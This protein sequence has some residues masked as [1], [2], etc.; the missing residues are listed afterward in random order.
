[1]KDH[2]GKAIAF[3]DMGTNSMRLMIVR[4]DSDHAYTILTR[5]KEMIRLGEGEFEHGYIL[6][7]SMGRAVAVCK[8]FV[9]MAETF[10]A[11]ELVCVATAAVREANNRDDFLALIKREAGLDIHVISGTE[12]ARLIYLG[13]SRGTSVTERSLFID[14]GGGS[15][16]LVVGDG[17]GYEYLDS[18]KAGAIRLSMLLLY[19]PAAP[20]ATTSYLML[21]D[22]VRNK[23]IRSFQLIR[24]MGLMSAYGSSGTVQNLAEICC[25]ALHGGNP[26]KRQTLTLADLKQVA[27]LLCRVPLEE[28]MLIPGINPSR[29]DII[30]AGAAILETILT[31]LNIPS[32]QVSDRELRDGLLADYLSRID[33]HAVEEESSV[34]LASVLQLGRRS[35]F[36]EDHAR[37]VARLGLELFDSARDM[38]LHEQGAR[39]R[40]LFFSSSL[41]HD[42]GRFLSYT[43]HHGNSAYFIINADLLGFRQEELS[44]MA[45]TTY[46]HRKDLPGDSFPDFLGLP[47]AARGTV[48]GQFIFLRMAESLD[49]SH[50]GLVEGVS[51]LNGKRGGAVLEIR[52]SKSC[53]LELWGIEKH[54]ETFEKYYGMPLAI[55]HVL[56]GE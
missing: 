38:G 51:F 23:S 2:L 16:E 49:R 25:Q 31:D 9:G 3:M 56:K 45:A 33:K 4:L 37:R 28:R 36:D 52:S 40:E 8:N 46:F 18:I 19:D 11:S 30:V 44:I 50:A 6:E 42:V 1:M 14:I 48:K 32:I 39:E 34:R 35:S 24:G 21:Q 15:T 17:Q 55:S 54:C 5:Q 10:N 53:Q 27:S 41:L 26:E 13:V 47:E 12:E 43:N 29:A 7:E 22:Y 20:I